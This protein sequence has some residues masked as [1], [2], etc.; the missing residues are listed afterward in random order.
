MAARHCVPNPGPRPVHSSARGP[1]RV[2]SD[3]PLSPSILPSLRPV[4]G[5]S[6]MEMRIAVS[7]S[8]RLP[9]VLRE[10][11]DSGEYVRRVTRNGTLLFSPGR[12][13]LFGPRAV[14]CAPARVWRCGSLRTCAHA[15]GL[16]CG[17]TTRARLATAKPARLRF[18]RPSP[19]TELCI[20]SRFA[21]PYILC[22][23]F[24][25]AT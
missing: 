17:T 10:A 2:Y 13:T 11:Q 20:P 18:G 24:C 23:H 3:T 9:Q 8:L 21:E 12:R 14:S 1:P 15:C 16:Q 4:L 6:K 22:V 19:S 25:T 7:G 5:S